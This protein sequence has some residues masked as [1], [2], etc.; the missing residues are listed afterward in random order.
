[1]F[2]TVL[3]PVDGSSGS[4][5]TA[6]H[7]LALAQKYGATI[8]ALYVVDAGGHFG[9]VDTL[10]EESDL[11]TDLESAGTEALDHVASRAR[12]LDLEFE[13]ELRTGDPITEILAGSR[14][15][16]ADLLV[17]G[18]HQ[19][20]RLERFLRKSVVEEV[21][22]GTSVP[23][24]TI[25][26]SDVA[27]TTDYQ[28][29]L[30]ATDGR[31]GANRAA[32]YAFEIA[33]TYDAS[34]HVLTVLDQ[35]LT[36]SSSLRSY[37]EDEADRTL[38]GVTGAAALQNISTV[39]AQREGV[40]HEEIVAYAE[41]HGVDLIIMGSSNRPHIDRLFMGSVTTN[42]L[43]LSSYPLLIVPLATDSY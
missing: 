39:T 30:F 2:D 37:L 22:R 29:V 24:L 8:H 38:Q 40:P 14:D 1:M 5:R 43:R 25:R 7:G 36:R 33:A 19:R 26:A 10:S 3:L 31:A 21:I 34:L 17:M 35:R 4:D 9:S 27:Q 18:S 32:R 12:D 23:V 28:T 13:R 16:R 42:T 11:W 15:S 6:E 20:G 41:R